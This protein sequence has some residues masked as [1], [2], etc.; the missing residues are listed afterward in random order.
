VRKC[1]DLDQLLHQTGAR[2][3]ERVSLSSGFEGL[4]ISHPFPEQLKSE[5]T[6][7]RDLPSVAGAFGIGAGPAGLASLG[8]GF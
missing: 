8:I 7:G 4:S 3:S 2:A 1:I 5:F 6:S